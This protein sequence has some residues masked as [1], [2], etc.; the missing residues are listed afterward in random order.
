MGDD[1]FPPSL[2][3]GFLLRGSFP[4]HHGFARCR[5]VMRHRVRR[6]LVGKGPQ[7]VCRRLAASGQKDDGRKNKTGS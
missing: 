4:K 3:W 7:R 5:V 1:D 2:R 6:A